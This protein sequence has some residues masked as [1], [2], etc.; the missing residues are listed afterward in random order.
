MA[1]DPRREH[2]EI[3]KIDKNQNPRWPPAA[4]LD[5]GLEVITFERLKLDFSNLAHG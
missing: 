5:F 3:I 4:I 2:G 1:R